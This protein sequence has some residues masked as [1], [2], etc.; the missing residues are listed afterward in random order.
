MKT[1]R[2][3]RVLQEMDARGLKQILISAP[4][5]IFYLTGK[6]FSPGE[7]MITLLIK[8]NG[9]HKLIVNK[10]FTVEEALGVDLVWYGDAEDPTEVLSKLIDKN[11]VLGIDKTWP[12][13]FL[14]SLLER[15]AASGFFNSSPIM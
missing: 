9:E 5:S 3:A 12:S 13:H 4:P 1:E 8:S 11:E 10:L 15:H 2:V 7:R 6:W 14:F